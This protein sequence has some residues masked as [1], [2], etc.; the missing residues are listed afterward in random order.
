MQYPVTVA[1]NHE[2]ISKS[3]ERKT[4]IKS[5]TNIYKCE[6]IEKDDFTL[7]K[8]DCTK[9]EKNHKKFSLNILCSKKYIMLIIQTITQIVKNKLFF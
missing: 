8:D 2:E 3:P 9:F 7:K 6:G 1:L 4:K 5:F